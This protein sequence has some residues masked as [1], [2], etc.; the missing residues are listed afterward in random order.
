MKYYPLNRVKTNQRTTGNQFIL[1][2]VPYKGLYYE[3]YDGRYFTGPT[4]TQGPSQELIPVVEQT[5]QNIRNLKSTTNF[6]DNN[7]PLVQDY[8][9]INLR[10]SLQGQ[11][12]QVPRPY[13]PQPTETD[14]KRK[15][16][17]RYFAKKRDRAGYIIEVNKETHDSLKNTDSVYDYVT[18][19]TISTLWQ[20]SGP[21]YDDRTNRQY[22]IAG[23]IDTN[24]RLI[25]AKEPGFPG[26]IAYIGG[27][28]AKYAKPSS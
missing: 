11:S 17:M 2:G 22:K 27:D 6:P 7:D 13:Y 23:I 24:K 25:E 3:T 1:N 18:Y 14:Y 26:L 16:I 9:V 5:V 28:Y 4:P 12:F 19:E 8:D 15:S 21:L 10:T 20:I